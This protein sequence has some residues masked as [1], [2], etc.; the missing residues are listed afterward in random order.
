MS[1][2]SWPQAANGREPAVGR[3][4]T[5][6][7]GFAGVHAL[8]A[9]GGWCIAIR[10]GDLPD[11][12]MTMQG[13]AESRLATMASPA[14]LARRGE[15]RQPAE[16]AGHACLVF[17]GGG[18]A[19]AWTS[20]KA[21]GPPLVHRPDGPLRANDGEQLRVALLAHLGIAQVRPG[22]WHASWRRARCARCST[23]SPAVRRRF[24]RCI[25][26]GAGATLGWTC[27]SRIWPRLSRSTCRA[28]ASPDHGRAIKP[29]SRPGSETRRDRGP[30]ASAA[31]CP[32]PTRSA[33]W[34]GCSIWAAPSCGAP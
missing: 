25:R 3:D 6:A 28:S 24:A 17:T 16:L 18:E 30:P 13:L 1:V 7:A 31:A 4:H 9:P 22:W 29:A 32:G 23:I 11:S 8:L 2:R 26:R 15:P 33:R 12:S 5:T 34:P 10:H 27:S 21:K 19:H 20:R 14:Y